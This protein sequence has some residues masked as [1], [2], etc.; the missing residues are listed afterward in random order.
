MIF[1]IADDLTGAS[2]TGVKYEK[3]GYRVIVETEYNCEDDKFRSW[4]EKYDVVSINANTRLLSSE[5]AYRKIH[6]LT[7]QIVRL[8][9]KYIYKKIDSLLRGNPAVE[10]DAVID[11]MDSDIALV[12]PSFP[13]NGRKL[14]GGV[15]KADGEAEI[16]VIKIFQDFS[17][18]PVG[19]ICLEDIR[20]DPEELSKLIEAKHRNG[21]KVLVFDA[22]TDRDLE[23]ISKAAENLPGKII[24]CGSAGF[25]KYLC[26]M[27]KYANFL[28][29]E[30]KSDDVI[31]VVA[32]SRR[33][34]TARQLK[35]IS[36]F[37]QTPIVTINTALIGH[38]P[39]EEDREIERCRNKIFNLAEN[40]HSLILF[41]VS[42][43]F[44]EKPGKQQQIQDSDDVCI[45]RALGK[46]VEEVYRKIR[47]RTV[48]STGGDTSFQV[49]KALNADGIELHDEISA[50]VPIGKI[51][52]GSANGMTIVTKSGG[53][54]DG[55]I[56]IRII[57]YLKNL[58]DAL[59]TLKIKR[60]EKKEKSNELQ[61]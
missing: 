31:L 33:P 36:E 54:G 17:R 25:A 60:S 55:D 32:G 22:T 39:A 23:V 19:N 51:V 5:E 29:W 13:E 41:A 58:S 20:R 4:L 9:P 37:Y 61:N 49:C 12:V 3:N 27:E 40:G 11:A 10:L 8:N 16:N 34:E 35:S 30:A 15:L 56:L 46:T 2:D 52:G 50:G 26:R 28:Q 6:D 47:F 7:L 48:I 45:T 38:D 44:P 57:S 24:F 14:I 43:L 59:S 18:Y 1:I 21:D 53:F 42:S